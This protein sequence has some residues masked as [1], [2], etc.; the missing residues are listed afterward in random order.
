MSTLTPANAANAENIIKDLLDH[1]GETSASPANGNAPL[2]NSLSNE[3]LAALLQ[4]LRQQQTAITT[5]TNATTT[6]TP[7]ATPGQASPNP[8][9]PPEYYNNAKY[10]DIISKP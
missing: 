10:E 4:L 1:L 5:L 8:R 2:P 7:S 3:H 9:K 6:S